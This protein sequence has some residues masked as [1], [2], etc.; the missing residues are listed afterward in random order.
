MVY[1]TDYDHKT[2]K[3]HCNVISASWDGELCLFDDS[4]ADR[5]GSSRPTVGKHHAAINF[6]DFNYD[7]KLSATASDDGEVHLH[8]H[9]S[10]RAEGRLTPR[11]GNLPEVKICKFL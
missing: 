4:S 8:N 1:W 10:H 2:K 9:F 5:E 11:G 3:Q 7:Q 6:V